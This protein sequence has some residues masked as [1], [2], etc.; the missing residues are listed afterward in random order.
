MIPV[1]RSPPLEVTF[2]QTPFSEWVT[3]MWICLFSLQIGRNPT[4]A[5]MH[6][7]R[8]HWKLRETCKILGKQVLLPRAL[9]KWHHLQ[10]DSGPIVEPSLS[11]PGANR[12]KG[13]HGVSALGSVMSKLRQLPHV[14][15]DLAFFCQDE[16]VH[17]PQP[18]TPLLGL[19]L[20]EMW[21]CSPGDSSTMFKAAL[22]EMAKH[23]K[24]NR[25]SAGE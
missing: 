8:K 24:P 25:L 1:S 2:T 3:L 4:R 7:I 21:T 6:P 15:N 17:T 23:R 18:S 14:G 10:R 11:V 16:C 13:L 9:K 20:Q 12:P 22:F 19:Y 5:G